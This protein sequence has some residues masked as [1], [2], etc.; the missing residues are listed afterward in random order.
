MKLVELVKKYYE[1]SGLDIPDL[2]QQLLQ[3]T[4]IL[5]DGLQKFSHHLS[6]CPQ[7]WNYDIDNCCCGLNEME[8]ILYPERKRAMKNIRITEV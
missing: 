3:T 7:P 8:K 5:E 1:T 4:E 6:F 2:V